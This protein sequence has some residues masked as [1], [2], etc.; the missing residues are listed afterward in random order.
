MNCQTS[1]VIQ[2]Y[3]INVL[4]KTRFIIVRVR[5]LTTKHG[6]RRRRDGRRRGEL[7]QR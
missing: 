7:A 3:G 6:R 2:F 5:V 4:M 1:E